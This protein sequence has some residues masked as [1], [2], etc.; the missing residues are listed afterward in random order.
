VWDELDEPLGFGAN[1]EATAPPTRK[2]GRG[3][4]IGAAILAAAVIV[5]TVSRRDFPAQGEPFAIARLEAA[6]APKEV[7]APDVTASVKPTK[8]PPAAATA[9]VQVT[10]GVKADSGG[11][12]PRT[13]LII[14]VAQ[15]LA[16][17]SPPVSDGRPPEK[18]RDG[19]LPRVAQ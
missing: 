19:L 7:E 15:A 17:R 3:M 14:D 12:G 13:P 16:A 10:S 18:S 2:R 5:L 11:S 8:P 9:Q 6:P 4:A 1:A